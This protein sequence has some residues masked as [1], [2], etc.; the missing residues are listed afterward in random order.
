MSES[1]V[2]RRP[3]ESAGCSGEPVVT[4]ARAFYTTR[5]AAGATGTRFSLRPLIFWGGRFA[6][7]G[8]IAPRE[9]GSVFD[10][11]EHATLGRRRPRKRAIQYSE[12]S[13]IETKV[14]GVLDTRFRGYD[15]L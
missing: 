11:C 13:V 1:L 14:R 8:R 6:Q 9:G 7:L 15:G 12:T 2:L 10:E 5:A 4:N 3:F